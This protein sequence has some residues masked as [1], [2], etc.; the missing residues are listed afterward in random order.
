MSHTPTKAPFGSWASPIS[1]QMITRGAAGLG[2][3]AHLDG[4]DLWLEFR[5]WEAGRA[6]LTSR[7]A[8]GK[9]ED[10]TPPPLNL[11]S[12]VHEYGGDSF[13]PGDGAIWFIDFADQRVWRIPPGGTPE[14]IGARTGA[15]LGEPIWD[16]THHRLILV[17]EDRPLA[18]E[19]ENRLVAMDRHGQFHTLAEGAD[20]YAFP[21]PS[22]DG[23]RL[24]W[25]EWSHPDM[26]WDQAR[27]C[28]ATLDENGHPGSKTVL[29]GGQ[30]IA[31]FQPEWDAQGRLLWVD[32]RDGWWRLYREDRPNQPLVS[33]EA[34]F[35]LP[36]WQLGAHSYRPLP[37]GRIF[38]TYCRDGIWRSGLI[39]PDAGTLEELELGLAGLGPFMAAGAG[40]VLGVAHW[41]DRPS[42]LVAID[43]EGRR[44]EILHSSMSIDVPEGAISRPQPISFP[45]AQGQTAH[46]FYYPP[47]NAD[48]MGL[49][50]EK[51]PLIVKSHGGP[52]SQTS[53]SFSL[54]IQFWTSRGFA[55]LDVNYS[56]ST[57]YGRAYRDRL[58]GQ[59]GLA[60]V[61]DVAA[62]AR[63]L[64]ERGLADPAR[65]IVTGGSAGGYTTL[66]ALTFTDVFQAG[67]SSYGIGD[68]E[69]LARDTHKFES[70]YLDALV[71]PWPQAAD[72]YRARSPIHHVDRLNCPVIFLQGADD[73]VVPPNQAEAMVEAL[74]AK[75][76]PVAYILFE[77]EGHGFRKADSVR[78]AL[79]SELG[80]YGRIFG[81]TPAG[82]IEYPTIRNLKNWP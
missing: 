53:P 46:G 25:L 7:G 49:P 36:L 37:D 65:L 19:P 30:G 17:A 63:F 32:D 12:R 20:F 13:C 10:L 73:K 48:F 29:A 2:Q 51:P 66:S 38:A 60:D 76:V 54:K 9:V 16:G 79:E 11:R 78:R 70:R 24:A 45:G 26:P 35:G 59:W 18:G 67:C 43:L 42:A 75:G 6:I 62:G 23:K 47:T 81:F 40:K 50:D 52:T 77:G 80:F 41:V 71:G 27:L 5:P 69:T 55:V 44:V 14:A 22:P 58:K 72:I 74:D 33:V 8:D 64:A 57:G 31:A 21:R 28:L 3:V 34:E 39:D 68:L 15:G 82:E 56:G 1:S 4:L 61:A